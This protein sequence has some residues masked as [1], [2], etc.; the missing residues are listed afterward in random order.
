MT[1]GLL[2][3]VGKNIEDMPLIN[4]PEIT[5]FKCQFKRHT[6][7]TISQ[8]KEILSTNKCNKS[9]TKYLLKKGDLLN[10]LYFKIIINNFELYEN[11]TNITPTNKNSII[12]YIS[13]TIDNINYILYYF[14][15]WK[16]MT[17]HLLL[18]NKQQYILNSNYINNLLKGV[19]DIKDKYIELYFGWKN[20]NYAI[21]NVLI[22]TNI[23][24]QH[25]YNILYTKINKSHILINRFYYNFYF[26]KYKNELFYNYMLLYNNKY[27]ILFAYN[28]ITEIEILY[29][30]MNNRNTNNINQFDTEILYNYCNTNNYNFN[31]YLYN[32]KN[33]SLVILLALLLLYNNNNFVFTKKY[34]FIG[35]TIIN[36][37]LIE[38]NVIRNLW[39]NILNNKIKELY[40]EINMFNKLLD[41]LKLL[42]Y[43]SLLSIIEDINNFLP[44][45]TILVYIKLKKISDKF[46]SIYKNKDY[47]KGINFYNLNY[48]SFDPLLLNNLYNT[49]ISQYEI[50]TIK[51]IESVD[52]QNIFINIA[53]DL[54]E[55]AN[56]LLLNNKIKSCLVFWRN[57]LT[58]QLYKIFKEKINKTV[59]IDND[60]NFKTIFHYNLFPAH[61]YTYSTFLE[62]YYK[63]F[64]T[65]SFLCF[66]SNIKDKLYDN[67]NIIDKKQEYID[68]KKLFNLSIKNT[69]II[70]SKNIIYENKQIKFK[71]NNYYS[72][73]TILLKLYI[74]EIEIKY[75]NAFF[76][77][78]KNNSYM[79]VTINLY[80]NIN[81]HNIN[82]VLEYTNKL[83]VLYFN[84]TSSLLN[85]E[86]S[87]KK[88][89][90]YDRYTLNTRIIDNNYIKINNY[91]ENNNIK[92]LIYEC[93]QQTYSKIIRLN[94]GTSLG[95]YKVTDINNKQISFL[96]DINNNDLIK[97]Y[98]IEYLNII[99]KKF[100]ESSY[101]LLGL[102]IITFTEKINLNHYYY[103]IDKYNYKK[104]IKL[105]PS[106]KNIIF[107]NNNITFDVENKYYFVYKTAGSDKEVHKKYTIILPNT[108]PP[109]I[110]LYDFKCNNIRLT[111]LTIYKV[112]N[113]TYELITKN[114]ND[115]SNIYFYD[116]K[117]NNK[118][119]EM[120]ETQPAPATDLIQFNWSY[121]DNPIKIDTIISYYFLLYREGTYYNINKKIDIKYNKVDKEI[122]TIRFYKFENLLTNDKLYMYRNNNYVKEILKSENTEI[123][124]LDRISN[125]TYL[126]NNILDVSSL[127]V[128]NEISYLYNILLDNRCYYNYKYSYFNNKNLNESIPNDIVNIT[129]ITSFNRQLHLNLN[130]SSDFNSIKIYRTKNANLL[131]ENENIFYELIILT[132]T[133]TNYISIENK[134]FIF[135]DNIEDTSLITK[136]E[137][138]YFLT[139][140]PITP[141]ILNT[142]DIISINNNIMPNLYNFISHSTD[143]S[144]ATKK[145]IT[146]T[147]DFIFNESFIILN[148]TKNISNIISFYNIPFLINETS[149]IKLENEILNYIFD[150]STEQFFNNSPETTTHH[151]Y[152][153]IDEARAPDPAPA[154][155]LIPD[156]EISSH[157]FNPSFNEFLIN[158]QYLI[159]NTSSDFINF[160]IK[161]L[162]DFIDN[163]ANYNKIIKL[164]ESINLK[165]L[166]TFT[167]FFNNI[168]GITSN[169]IINNIQNVINYNYNN[170]I[171]IYNNEKYYIYNRNTLI[172]DSGIGVKT[173]TNIYLQYSAQY[174]LTD[175]IIN[176]LKLI[177]IYFTDHLKHITDNITRLQ[178]INSDNIKI[179]YTSYNELISNK[180]KLYNNENN[181]KIYLLHPLINE[182]INEVSYNN[183]LYKINKNE[184]N[185]TENTICLNNFKEVVAP[186]KYS[187]IDNI[188]TNKKTDD[189]TYIGPINNINNDLLQD[190]LY[191]LE[192]NNLYTLSELKQL[193]NSMILNPRKITIIDE[194]DFNKLAKDKI[195][196]FEEYQYFYKIQIIFSN[197][198]DFVLD[199]TIMI[200]NNNKYIQCDCE[201][202]DE[203]TINLVFEIDYM[204]V[205]HSESLICKINENKIILLDNISKY[206]IINL[207][208]FKY[209]Y[210]DK[211][212]ILSNKKLIKINTTYYYNIFNIYKN[213]YY[214]DFINITFIEIYN[215]I[216]IENTQSICINNNRVSYINNINSLSYYDENY[217]LILI[218]QLIPYYNVIKIKDYINN[219]DNINYLCWLY[220]KK[221]LNIITLDTKAAPN[222]SFYLINNNIT[223]IKSNTIFVD[224]TLVYLVDLT[225]LNHYEY[226]FK[227]YTE[228]EDVKL[229]N[230]IND[231]FLYNKNENI[232]LT[233]LEKKYIYKYKFIYSQNDYDIESDVFE[234]NINNGADLYDDNPDN[235]KGIKFFKFETINGYNDIILYRSKC[236]EDIFYKVGELSLD[237]LKTIT[238]I[239]PD[240]KLSKELPVIDKYQIEYTVSRNTEYTYKYIYIS[241][242]NIS[243]E[244]KLST[245]FDISA[246]N[247]IKLNI[248]TNINCNIYRTHKDTNK[249]YLLAANI[250]DNEF[251][252]CV[253][254]TYLIHEL[255]I[256]NF[257][258]DAITLTK[259]SYLYKYYYTF[260]NTITNSESSISDIF[261]V[262]NSGIIKLFDFSH[263]DNTEFD[264][265]NIY[266]TKNNLNTFYFLETISQSYYIDVKTDDMLTKE[267]TPI[268]NNSSLN[269]SI[270][271]CEYKYKFTLLNLI[272][273][274]ETAF[275]SVELAIV[276]NQDISESNIILNFKN[277]KY[278]TEYNQIKI[279]RT[280]NNLDTEY[281]YLATLPYTLNSSPFIDSTKDIIDSPKLLINN[282]DQNFILPIIEYNIKNNS[283]TINNYQLQY[284]F[285][286]LN[287]TTNTR[288]NY[289]PI[290]SINKI[291]NNTVVLDFTNLI[292]NNI[293]IEIYRTKKNEFDFYYIH[294]IDAPINYIDELYDSN[295]VNIVDTSIIS[296]ETYNL[297]LPKIIINNY[298]YN[299]KFSN[300][301][302]HISETSTVNLSCEI[303]INIVKFT[304]FTDAIK[305]YRTLGN[306]LDYYL[307]PSNNPVYPNY[308]ISPYNDITLNITDKREHNIKKA[309]YNNIIN[310]IYKY[311]FSYYDS[312]NN[313]ESFLSNEYII[314]VPYFIDLNKSISIN[315]NK[316]IYNSIKIYRTKCN[317]DIFYDLDTI[318]NNYIDTKNDNLLIREKYLLPKL[319]ITKISTD[320]IYKYKINLYNSI[321]KNEQYSNNII[322]YKSIK[323]NILNYSMITFTKSFPTEI[324]SKFDM[325]KIYRTKNNSNEFYLLTVIDINH[326]NI[327]DN[328]EDVYLYEKY[329]PEYINFKY[330]Y[331]PK[332]YKYC[333]IF[334]NGINNYSN[335]IEIN[336]NKPISATNKIFLKNINININ[337][338][339]Y[340]SSDGVDFNYV[341]S[342]NTK[343]YFDYGTMDRENKFK[344]PDITF[345]S[346]INLETYTYKYLYS[347]KNSDGTL[348]YEIITSILNSPINN[349]KHCIITFKNITNNNMLYRTKNN[350]FDKYYLIATNVNKFI[351]DNYDDDK[352][353]VAINPPLNI[354]DNIN[355]SIYIPK[356]TYTYT[357]L[358]ISNNYCYEY[359]IIT[360]NIINESNKITITINN[361]ELISSNQNYLYKKNYNSNK[362]TLLNTIQS[363]TFVH[364]NID[365]DNIPI[366]Y[367]ILNSNN[368]SI[369]LNSI[370]RPI[371]T[372]NIFD[373]K[374]NCTYTII[375]NDK[376]LTSSFIIVYENDNFIQTN[377]NENKDSI[378]TN[379][380][381]L[382]KLDEKLK[383]ITSELSI[384]NIYINEKK[385]YIKKSC[386]LLNEIQLWKIVFNGTQYFYIW[387]IYTKDEDIV[388]SYI[389]NN[390]EIAEPINIV[391]KI[392]SELPTSNN[393][394][395]TCSPNIFKKIDNKYYYNNNIYTL[396]SYTKYYQKYY[397]INKIVLLK[398]IIEVGAICDIRPKLIEYN[399]SIDITKIIYYIYIYNNT[400]NISSK[401]IENKVYDKLFVSLDFP[402]FIS[403][404]IIIYSFLNELF[405]NLNHL[406]LNINDI[407]LINKTFFKILGLCTVSNL[408]EVIIIDG[409]VNL[410]NYQFD[411]F[412]I[413][414][415]Y[416]NST[417][418]DNIEPNINIEFKNQYSLSEGELYYYNNTL[419][420]TYV[421]C[422]KY[423]IFVFF[424]KP[425]NIKL[426]YKN[427]KLY[428]LSKSIIIKQ[429]DILVYQDKIINITYVNNNVLY[430]NNNSSIL[431]NT[432]IEVTYPYQPFK[433][434]NI[435]ELSNTDSN[436]IIFN[437]YNFNNEKIYNLNNNKLYFNEEE[438]ILNKNVIIK[439]LD[440]HYYGIFNNICVPVEKPTT[441][442]TYIDY[443]NNYSIKLF[444]IKILNL[445]IVNIENMSKYKF[446]YMQP[447]Y[448][449]GNLNYL[450][451][452]ITFNTVQYVFKFKYNVNTTLS[453]IDIIFSSLFE[454]NYYSDTKLNLQPTNNLEIYHYK[455]K[456][457]I[458]I[459]FNKFFISK[460][461]DLKKHSSKH[462]TY[463]NL[464][465]YNYNLIDINTSSLPIFDLYIDNYYL[466]VEKDTIYDIVYL[467]K[468]L[469]DSTF[470]FY[471]DFKFE[472]DNYYFI[473]KLIKCTINEYNEFITYDFNLYQ[474]KLYVKENIHKVNLIYKYELIFIGSNKYK[475][476]FYHQ[477]IKIILKNEDAS[478]LQMINKIHIDIEKDIFYNCYI[479]NAIL[480]IYSDIYIENNFFD[481]YIKI[482]NY[483][484]SANY[485]Q[486]DNKYELIKY[487][488]KVNNYL[489]DSYY[490]RLVDDTTYDLENIENGRKVGDY[491]IYKK[492]TKIL[493]NDIN[494]IE[495]NNFFTVNTGNIPIQ[496]I[497]YNIC[498]IFIINKT[499]NIFY[500][501][502]IINNGIVYNDLGEE[503][504]SLLLNKTIKLSDIYYINKPWKEWSLIISLENN[505]EL[506]KFLYCPDYCYI[507]FDENN[508]PTLIKEDIINNDYLTFNDYN[509]ITTFLS[510]YKKD[511]YLFIKN[512]VEH[513]IYNNL[514][515]WIKNIYF[516]YNALDNINIVLKNNF[517]NLT[518]NGTN[519]IFDNL[520]STH[521]I[522]DEYTVDTNLNRIYRN[523]NAIN[524]ICK[525]FDGDIN[526]TFGISIDKLLKSL[527]DISKD[528]INIYSNITNYKYDF[529]SLDFFTDYLT[530]K[531][532]ETF[533]FNYKITFKQNLIQYTNSVFY[534]NIINS[535]NYIIENNILLNN[536]K[537]YNNVIDF[538]INFKLLNNPFIIINNIHTYENNIIDYKGKLIQIITD[539]EFNFKNIASI[540]YNQSIL[541]IDNYDAGIYII[542]TINIDIY[543]CL[544][545]N[546]N[547]IINDYY[548]NS[549]NNKIYLNFLNKIDYIDGQTFISI[550]L[551]TYI[552]LYD[553]N[554]LY[555]IDEKLTNDFVI[556]NSIIK[557]KINIKTPYHL[558]I[559]SITEYTYDTN[560]TKIYFDTLP[561]PLNIQYILLNKKFSILLKYDESQKKCYIDIPIENI[562]ILYLAYNCTFSINE[563]NSLFK[564]SIPY[565]NFNININE[566]NIKILVNDNILQYN[567][568]NIVNNI[569]NVYLKNQLK[570]TNIKLLNIN[571]LGLY[572]I[573]KIK[574]ITFVDESL[575]YF[576][577]MYKINTTNTILSILETQN[578]IKYN[579]IENKIY[580]S[581][582]S[583]IHQI[584]LIEEYNIIDFQ[585]INDYIKIDISKLFIYINSSDFSYSINE[586]NYDT[587]NIKDSYLYISNII[588][589]T[590]I[591]IKKK[592]YINKSIIVN[593]H[594]KKYDIVLENTF[595]NCDTNNII[596]L[597]Y[598]L[599]DYYNEYDKTIMPYPYLYYIKLNIELLTLN[600]Q[601]ILVFTKNNNTHVG[602]IYNST[603]IALNVYIK[604]DE[605]IFCKI[606]NFTYKIQK[607][608]YKKNIFDEI[609]YFD[610]NTIYSNEI[611]QADRFNLYIV[612]YDDNNIIKDKIFFNDKIKTTTYNKVE[613]NKIDNYTNIINNI[614]YYNI[615]EYI[616]LYFN[617]Q[618]IDELN[619]D[620]FKINYY[621][622]NNQNEKNKIDKLTKIQII[623]NTIEIIIPLIF[624]FNN[625]ST[626]SL[627]LIA[628]QNTDIVL[629][630]KT[631][632]LNTLL[633][634]NKYFNNNLD[635]GIE[636]YSEY[637]F[638]DEDERKKINLSSHEYIINNYHIYNTTHIN[639]YNSNSYFKL[640]GLIK[641]IYL[642]TDSINTQYI[643]IYDNKYYIYILCKKYL[644]SKNPDYNFE[645]KYKNDLQI[646]KQSVNNVTIKEKII[647]TF[648][649]HKYFNDDLLFYLIYYTEKY[650]LNYTNDMYLLYIYL[651]TEFNNNVISDINI[652]NNIK[653][654]LDNKDLITTLPAEYFNQVV[655]HTKF[656]NSLPNNYYCF[657]FSLEP[658]HNQPSGHLNFDN[659]AE[660]VVKL[661]SNTDKY[662]MKLVS[663]N[664]NIIKIIGGMAAII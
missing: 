594:L 322:D 556:N 268:F 529:T 169:K 655:P 58:I 69:Y 640:N 388:N 523:R 399:N 245:K 278:D 165:Y 18:N 539:C 512:K 29:A 411:G 341:N 74:N 378:N 415:T 147:N 397:N 192:D 241:Q 198:I 79:G 626:L 638:L 365:Y 468:L 298:C 343:N 622:Y 427:N 125:S 85:N 184:T 458:L 118:I 452:I 37:L 3:L 424:N 604:E 311:K 530:N 510:S 238:D 216:T 641:D 254:D 255:N 527:V 251:I 533:D 425:I 657:T 362:Y 375:I 203:Y 584:L 130:M 150:I 621:L 481:I 393:Y 44:N 540:K 603:V 9:Y 643:P 236:N 119:S 599:L 613:V 100:S 352:L 497:N 5:F 440:I 486:L 376:P 367:T 542:D 392:N 409:E 300:N 598:K 348:I 225:I 112:D 82:I 295:L 484:N 384:S 544:E 565:L 493:K 632:D 49:N 156:Y 417:T 292:F 333:Y 240:G 359:I 511:N 137:P 354:L 473:N 466:L 340:R 15:G 129:S 488:I 316:S 625:E 164:I 28:N 464:Y 351:I 264:S 143:T 115:I 273:S 614:K 429:Y 50:N 342:T 122:I 242:N 189:F 140:E 272:S 617:S 609:I 303:D 106:K 42:Y 478:I 517:S 68:T 116:E 39:K 610:T 541:E 142:S 13:I 32:L 508:K 555:Y 223:F 205:L 421:E 361:Y 585:V 293:Y 327:I 139:T 8:S 132:N 135:V 317:S 563:S 503:K 19:I 629:K 151:A 228:I 104:F 450:S 67:I 271:T 571:K 214:F 449:G 597:P 51:I 234:I 103:L 534:L 360:N 509:I 428:N 606:N 612:K 160:I 400:I 373:N 177:P 661:E 405:L 619:S 1:G 445:F 107:N 459:E 233:V 17:E 339:I 505:I 381:Y 274:R 453:K 261:K 525:H 80:N 495:N 546:S 275:T 21:N 6:N 496:D 536:C 105:I 199:S 173:I 646:I 308:I 580:F 83:P 514:Y 146:D 276:I 114:E 460:L 243:D 469:N 162:I 443:I 551:K 171:Y 355:F 652:I 283:I 120:L 418:F 492:Y 547:I 335:V 328:I 456:N 47:S 175:D 287:K 543:N 88:Y 296:Q 325:I 62:S 269:I 477:A 59:I 431:D 515:L 476:G 588:N 371:I 439:Y 75:I 446:Y 23:I 246:N 219:N 482:D 390:L 43:N 10:N 297:A 141:E 516:F 319:N 344:L 270:F 97:I 290:I 226:L 407:I 349:N 338:A 282:T 634:N 14:N 441:Q 522:T 302:D 11:I 639:E 535:L 607:I 350:E 401:L 494:K 577:Y 128:R 448:I 66:A 31:N 145:N 451:D 34:K 618:L 524:N 30:Y 237:A 562:D 111:T 93:T 244:Y 623:N 71:F 99:V 485:I 659:I 550:N 608:L 294:K 587:L 136:Y 601:Y 480:Y 315:L 419:Y 127:Q 413:F 500:N 658:L 374:I 92:I 227:Q 592:H 312:D 291:N 369:H 289:S 526:N 98:I 567:K 383:D 479:D 280:K 314:T 507:E 660:F 159:T 435:D 324:K 90:I 372:S 155:V 396:N 53:Y 193:F 320:L 180:I 26:D 202:V 346:S 154:R 465:F 561:K 217:Y 642:I 91:T 553:A 558:I 438:I 52:L 133:N 96:K 284:K 434:I 170:N 653:F 557:Y 260:Y 422:I 266:R 538:N 253:E 188:S 152:Y 370:F 426:F 382:G 645:N 108:L 196:Y 578:S 57:T 87:F 262:E 239:T 489:N 483:I 330:E 201:N 267:G 442:N 364:N 447:V 286:I 386:L 663:K 215:N 403:C 212:Y 380:I 220:K 256:S 615:F 174:I 528:Y 183:I 224:N 181:N 55:S 158:P 182:N 387:T 662:T 636:L 368:I 605:I 4:K 89:D 230:R 633:N 110:L 95:L 498:D 167:S 620:V 153:T 470:K 61:I 190:A 113:D 576:E 248:N 432:F 575:Y 247:P 590:T 186:G 410:N 627:P 221:S 461:D 552:L 36:N 389:E 491:F 408:Y 208:K 353:N 637:T 313:I 462:P 229:S 334:R 518:F 258:L 471:T 27:D 179:E 117:K 572:D 573:N 332:N 304:N 398:D 321:N 326:N 163:D 664:Y 210:E 564:Y 423:N 568:Y 475:N 2:Q 70:E 38:N 648:K 323:I 490:Y 235:S 472:K 595:Y 305:I 649:N 569:F 48:R 60:L 463:T 474:E 644:E 631:N 404:K 499:N 123:Y 416:E 363:N 211:D 222:N 81:K 586:I 583:N 391:S 394:T 232:I 635:M 616:K 581:T 73:D 172:L 157:H 520:N 647:K 40:L 309:N 356:P 176:Y 191:V 430:F 656:N 259:T 602:I 331:M 285:T 444:A 265:I 467:V 168:N 436:F 209:K 200:Y 554:L 329:I 433:I 414:G 94:T 501:H 84:E 144:F 101:K 651:T 532:N 197:K 570:T 277:I 611:I 41:E 63:I 502:K 250:I 487:S 548:S 124:I 600:Q 559:C 33:N 299:Y 161:S 126:T 307:L 288:T 187:I 301:N 56:I 545:F 185:L 566:D 102:K 310:N 630:Y 395:L 35:N 454:T 437:L 402:P 12:N 22:K 654:A 366:D 218:N 549:N 72:K 65:N 149:I 24:E 385:L 358:L 64:Y 195:E 213:N 574:T 624:W 650:L 249:Y 521:Y 206:S 591:N 279:Y 593:T 504:F 345:D 628:M 281:Y 582:N 25:I 148:S 537:I 406:Y 579:L 109:K 77:F 204:I 347:Y 16:L 412:Y 252:D 121:S 134:Q 420:L 231:V 178:L 506:K 194:K 45:D 46:N 318:S 377:Y 531:Y 596:I 263:L 457:D 207:Y 560:K 138:I 54:L 379:L 336:S 7:F 20:Y 513:V 131:Y 257:N 76:E 589:T 306:Q 78:D 519:L 455:I 337:T 86:D 357:Y 166:N